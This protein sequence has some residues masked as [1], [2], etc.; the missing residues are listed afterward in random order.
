MPTQ[1]IISVSVFG[2]MYMTWAE[3]WASFPF[4]QRFLVEIPG[5][6]RFGPDLLN[7]YMGN[8]FIT[9]EKRTNPIEV[10]D[11]FETVIMAAIERGDITDRSL[12][13]KA[14]KLHDKKKR[15]TV[16]VVDGNDG[17]GVTCP[18]C[19]ISFEIDMQDPAKI[20]RVGY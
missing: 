17:F 9:K 20:G 7:E 19:G 10:G 12:Y 6:H 4:L 14:F 18:E 15:S 2:A 11:K 16:E 5:G 3:I 8:E 13:P 1:E